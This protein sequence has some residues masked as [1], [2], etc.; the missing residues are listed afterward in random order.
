MSQN[1]LNFKTSKTGK[2]RLIKGSIWQQIKTTIKGES[3]EGYDDMWMENDNIELL[4][5]HNGVFVSDSFLELWDVTSGLTLLSGGYGSSKTTY[6]VTRLLIKCMEEK[7]FRCYYGRQKKTE[8][9]LLHATFITEIKR[10]HWEHLFHYS[11]TPTGSPR[12]THNETGNYFELFGCD[13]TESLKGLDK[14]TDIYIDEINQIDFSA[15]GMLITR[16]RGSG[17]EKQLFGCFN[18]CDVSADH[19]LR[20]YIYGDAESTDEKEQATLKALSRIKTVKHHSTYRDNKFQNPDEYYDKLIVKAAGDEQ[21]TKAY[22]DGEWEVSLELKPFYK[23]FKRSKHVKEEILIQGYMDY[24]PT[25]ALHISWDENVNPYL[26]LVV[27]QVDGTSVYAIDEI[28]GKNPNNTLE[29][30]C[31]EFIQRYHYDLGHQAGLF[32]YGD[33]TSDKEDVKLEKGANFFTLVLGWLDIMNPVLRKSDSNP[34]VKMRGNFINT[35][36]FREYANIKVFFGPKCPKLIHDVEKCPENPDKKKGGKDKTKSMIDGVR[37]VQLWGHFSDCF[38]YFICE[39][40]QGAYLMYQAGG[41]SYNVKGGMREVKNSY[42][43]KAP[44]PIERDK[45]NASEKKETSI[46]WGSSRQSKNSY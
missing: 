34:N 46:S 41:R 32:V 8:A 10:N 13:D 27:F 16:Q 23:Q 12:I 38:D 28:A 1:T 21:L 5:K 26:P 15:F 43:Y 19:W 2:F 39:Y 11:E 37:G 24:N 35:I 40:F 14:A 30:V 33:A 45:T 3:G 42:D 6:V 22:A 36:F 31:G 17:Y 9:R 4:R 44:V 29:W 7:I 18:N 25:L 20:L